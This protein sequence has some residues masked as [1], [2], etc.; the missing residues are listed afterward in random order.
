MSPEVSWLRRSWRRSWISLRVRRMYRADLNRPDILVGLLGLILGLIGLTWLP[1]LEPVRRLIYDW[2]QANPYWAAGV[3]S[4]LAFV[5]FPLV[6]GYFILGTSDPETY[7]RISLAGRPIEEVFYWIASD[8]RRVCKK[9]LGRVG[10]RTRKLVETATSRRDREG[11]QPALLKL[12]RKARGVSRRLERGNKKQEEALRRIETMKHRAC[13]DFHIPIRRLCDHVLQYSPL[14][15]RDRTYKHL[16]D[17]ERV[18]TPRETEET[19]QAVIRIHLFLKNTQLRVQYLEELMAF[20]DLHELIRRFSAT[21]SSSGSLHVY[22]RALRQIGEGTRHGWW[23]LPWNEAEIRRR[24]LFLYRKQRAHPGFSLHTL[25]RKAFREG[26]GSEGDRSRSQEI[27]DA[28]DAIA[29]AK[30]ERKS[31]ALESSHW[32]ALRSSPRRLARI[33]ERSRNEIALNFCTWFQCRYGSAVESERSGNLYVVSHGYSNT[34]LHALLELENESGWLSNG[35][36]RLFFYLLPEEET[37]D[38]RLMQYELRAGML[39]QELARESTKPNEPNTPVE[40]EDMSKPQK[41]SENGA[42]E[43]IFTQQLATGDRHVLLNLLDPSQDRVLVLLGAESFDKDH[44]VV[45]PRG[46]PLREF[47][48]ELEETGTQPRVV[49]LAESYKQQR[50]LAQ[51]SH[52]YDQHFDRV[53]VYPRDTIEWV[54]TEGEDPLWIPRNSP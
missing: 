52:F 6:S 20:R 31:S 12:E 16:R 40:P 38:T 3:G 34:V 37:F 18:E 44:R 5:V 13:R 27:L 33:I 26:R 19:R 36:V 53:D 21:Y 54:I 45:H 22:A 14:I 17:W 46:M 28:L 2:V 8:A 15:Q 10:R 30:E 4:I 47:L 35:N 29:R 23:T 9:V 51:D 48:R 50:S 7:A 41:E 24:L 32:E 43:R 1:L 11:I 39:V 42:R 25:M 49:V